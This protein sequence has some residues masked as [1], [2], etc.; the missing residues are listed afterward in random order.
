MTYF[1]FW[2]HGQ[3][4]LEQL[5]VDFN[6]FHASIKLTYES[7]RKNVTFLDVDVNFLNRE[8]I[9]DLHIKDTDCH[10]YLHYT[11]SHLHHTKRSIYSVKLCELVG[12]AHLKKTLKYIETK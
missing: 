12:K 6:K 7:S 11:S 8:I 3:Y 4:K 5:L 2:T 10:Q 1:S 9:I